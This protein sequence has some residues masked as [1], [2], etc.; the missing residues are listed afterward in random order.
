MG[1]IIT[2]DVFSGRPN[3]VWQLTEQQDSELGEKLSSA[4][5]PTAQRP[6]GVFGGLGYRGFVISRS[7]DD[8]RGP[9]RFTV[10]EGILDHGF[11]VPNQIDNI[12]LESWLAT[13]AGT[14]VPDV[15]LQHVTSQIAEPQRS[16]PFQ[17]PEGGAPRC[18]PNHAADAPTYNPGMWNT[19]TVQPHNNC[20]NYAND[21]ITNTFAQPGRATGHPAAVMACPNVLAGATSD[22]LHAVPNFAGVLPKGGGWYVA[23]VIWPNVDYHWY[24][25]DSVGCWSH[26]PGQTAARNVDNAGNAIVD[27]KTCNRGP[28]TIFCSYMVTNRNVHIG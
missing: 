16:S 14:Q 8:P 28:Y 13:T 9:M 17:F 27:P 24:R 15:V 5:T 25:Q 10:H 6:S 18:P 26:K 4:G 20:Y 3:P 11:G 7:V 1:T 21:R 23:L 19:P 12:G 22:G 2:L